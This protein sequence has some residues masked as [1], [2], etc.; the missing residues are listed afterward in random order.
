[1]IADHI[2]FYP[3]N[4]RYFIVKICT[5]KLDLFSLFSVSNPQ[6]FEYTPVVLHN[7]I[8]GPETKCLLVPQDAIVGTLVLEF[9]FSLYPGSRVFNADLRDY[10][11]SQD[12]VA[13]RVIQEPRLPEKE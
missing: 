1:M 3:V 13:V 4:D 2:Y 6:Y 9:M 7:V 11:N 12:S 5:R 10:Q 8:I